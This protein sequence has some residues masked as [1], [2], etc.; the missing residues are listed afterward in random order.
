M[1]DLLHKITFDVQMLKLI[2]IPESPVNF[3]NNYSIVA[4]RNLLLFWLFAFK[5]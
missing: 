1:A 4:Q 5:L 3:N 2:P